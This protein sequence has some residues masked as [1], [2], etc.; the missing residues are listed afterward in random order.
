MVVGGQFI[1]DIY[2]VPNNLNCENVYYSLG[3]FITDI[4]S[5]FLPETI[6]ILTI[7]LLCFLSFMIKPQNRKLVI[8]NVCTLGLLLALFSLLFTA[9]N[10]G[11]NPIIFMGMFSSDLI[12]IIFRFIA[13]LTTLLVVGFSTNY[14]EKVYRFETE[15][16]ILLLTAALG[17]MLMAGTNDLIMTFIAVETVGISS[18]LLTG[19]IRNNVL[20][21]EAALKYLIIGTA[22]TGI[23]LFGMS[24]LYGLTG[25]TIFT[26]IA[27]NLSTPTNSIALF[28]AL[29]MI[30]AGVGYK[31]AV[32]P[33][34]VWAPDVYQGAPT[35]VTAFL[36]VA[37]KAA[38]FILMTR[39][40]VI[41]F[42][43]YPAWQIILTILAILSMFIGNL[44]A[45]I[46]TD[47]KRL[48]AYSS[49][50]HAGYITIGL[51]VAS[52]Y[53]LSSMI[54]YIIIYLFMQLGAWCS[55]L[56]FYNQTGSDKIEDYSGLVYKK[57]L[58]A[59]SF[60]ICL[61]SLAGIPITAG[62]FSK[63]FIFQAA[64]LENS[65]YTWLIIIALINSAISLYY[66]MR[67][68]KVMMLNEQSELVQN[69]DKENVHLIPQSKTLSFVLGFTVS[70]VLLLGIFALPLIDLSM[71]SVKQLINYKS[72]S[73]NVNVL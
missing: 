71:Y 72:N 64:I 3:N 46:Q 69:M 15:F 54:Y 31:M 44:T 68:V 24:Y 25:S 43:N 4:Q 5:G 13:L 29:I 22:S 48:L 21:N 11:N 35:P 9:K 14:F 39:I 47:I 41:I 66:Y 51:I 20:N 30:I 2:S 61:L 38:G 45:L 10:M 34:H 28:V 6:V 19:Y 23:L 27:Y 57:P 63:F 8:T 56:L 32:A 67:V 37:S 26:E 53:S 1:N 50:A 12:S 73:A 58:L 60:I 36:S 62:F 7:L 17:T 52:E 16:F 18:Y 40:I 55:I 49:I 42:Y 70:A 59:G 33:F 65:K